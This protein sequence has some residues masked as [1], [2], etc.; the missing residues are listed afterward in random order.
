MTL[1]GGINRIINFTLILLFC[2][3]L[4]FSLQSDILFPNKLSNTVFL[5]FP[6]LFFF[7]I[8]AWYFTK[9][10]LIEKV[11]KWLR[12]NSGKIFWAIFV[13]LV[14]YQIVLWFV[15]DT[16]PLVD[17]NYLLESLKNPA[18]SSDY[19]STY[20]NNL[21]FFFTNRFLGYFIDFDINA[22]KLVDIILIDFSIIF[23]KLAAER[24][25]QSKSI[26]ELSALSLL[27]YAGI[28]PL[29]LVPYTDTYALFPLTLAL[30]FIALAIE[31][32]RKAILFSSL[33]GITSGLT[34]LLR[35]SAIIYII[36]AL[37][38]VVLKFQRLV[39][40]KKISRLRKSIFPILIFPI[41]LAI[42]VLSF[43]FYLSHQKTITIDSKASMPIEHFLLLGSF[44]NPD[45]K[46]SLH[47][48]WNSGDVKLVESQKTKS[49]KKKVA[50]EKFIERTKERGFAKTIIFYVLKYSNNM[51]SGVV[52]YH[53]DG[54]WLK[55]KSEAKK[56]T[57][58]HV[59]QQIYYPTGKNR[60]TFNFICQ[61]V[62]IISLILSIYG[63]WIYKG[64]WRVGV[65]ALTLIGGL[66]F[67]EI[68]ESGGSK[69]FL[70]YMPFFSIL[71]ALG[72]KAF[73]DKLNDSKINQ[74]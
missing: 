49:D 61:I 4:F 34:Y 72:F 32:P 10:H 7:G 3:S 42:T 43:N 9:V 33:A 23:L 22:Y 45:V 56:G 16:V 31:V 26:G 13:F 68:F 55:S 54:L 2:L 46:N 44:G 41:M 15:L 58:S 59:I 69:Y 50:L 27:F 20:P 1:R 6:I 14:I 60:P 53:R 19:L 57:L 47:G 5:I 74:S 11:L 71:T 24:F 64:D 70:Q 25:F 37:I 12:K 73:Y 65:I 29:F 67:L 21:F 8:I 52:G 40:N 39:W 66:L 30:F 38:F 48:T 63:L 62:W 35:P 28:Q 51:D 17:S 18:N 36:A